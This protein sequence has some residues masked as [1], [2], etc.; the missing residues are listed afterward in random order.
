MSLK[1]YDRGGL[2]IH[3]VEKPT[4]TSYVTSNE[5]TYVLQ[6]TC[7]HAS[8]HCLR[9]VQ[10]F[11]EMFHLSIHFGV[12]KTYLVTF[13]FKFFFF[14]KVNSLILLM[15]VSIKCSKNDVLLAINHALYTS[16][17]SLY[18][19]LHFSSF[20]FSGIICFVRKY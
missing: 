5:I 20:S 15:S 4:F 18:S 19:V 9:A 16:C 6:C 17:I 1:T 14:L 2:C 12:G 3:H 7:T 10:I 8:T 13:H 11:P